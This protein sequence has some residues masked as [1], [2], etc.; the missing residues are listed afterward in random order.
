LRKDVTASSIPK[1]L[2]SAGQR[3]ARLGDLFEQLAG[4]VVGAE[5]LRLAFEIYQEA[6]A[7]HRRRYGV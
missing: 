2:S 6:M 1:L 7:Q 5:A 3:A 4:D